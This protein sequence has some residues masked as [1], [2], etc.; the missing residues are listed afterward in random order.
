MGMSV[1]TNIASMMASGKLNRTQKGLGNSLERISSGLRIN[2]AAD[3]AAGLGV[4]T[5]LETAVIGT[6]QAMRNTNDGI[7]IIQTT[8]SATQEVTDMLQRI[9]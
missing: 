7:S 4:A 6:Q 1:R 3:D 9:R 5:S 8:E 2:R